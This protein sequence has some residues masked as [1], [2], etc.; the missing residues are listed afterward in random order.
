MRSLRATCNSSSNT[1][2]CIGKLSSKADVRIEKVLSEI[3]VISE[4]LSGNIKGS[5][6]ELNGN[7]GEMKGTTVQ[8]LASKTEARVG[9]LD[10]MDHDNHRTQTSKALESV[11]AKMERQ[12][13]KG[14][15]VT[16]KDE[17]LMSKADSL[18]TDTGDNQ[19]EPVAY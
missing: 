7:I 6:G 11:M 19:G 12:K 9:K 5:I 18:E 15:N 2:V 1:H 8:A 3:R 4:R 16:M 13:M 14:H 10:E 17:N